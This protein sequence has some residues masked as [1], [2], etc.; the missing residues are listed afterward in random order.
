MTLSPYQRLKTHAQIYFFYPES[1]FVFKKSSNEITVSMHFLPIPA[2]IR[3]HNCCNTLADGV[4]VSRHVNAKQSFLAN[5]C[6]VLIDTMNG[7]TISHKVLGTG[8]NLLS[9]QMIGFK[10]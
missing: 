2:R 4:I 7:T 9:G 10:C 8:C 3:Y 1:E 6:I 5:H